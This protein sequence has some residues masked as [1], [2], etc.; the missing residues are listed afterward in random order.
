MNIGKF[1]LALLG[2]LMLGFGGAA[3]AQD[4][5]LSR[6]DALQVQL[7]PADY[8]PVCGERNGK[9]N[10]FQ[11]FCVAKSYGYRVL[12]GGKCR[13]APVPQ[14]PQACPRIYDPVCAE[15]RGVRQT[16]SNDC[17]AETRGYRV[18]YEGQC[19]VAPEPPQVCPRNYAPVCA[20]RNGKRDT[21]SND[22]VAETG[23]YRVVYEGQCRVAPEPPQVCP[24]NYAPVCAERNGK[25]DTFS[26]D[27][28]AE[29]RG[30]RVISEG[31]CQIAPRPPKPPR[32]E[33]CSDEYRPV[34]GERNGVR[35]TF[36]NVCEG[37]A[38]GYRLLYDSACSTEV[39]PRQPNVK[40]PRKWTDR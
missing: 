36:S 23:G 32:P 27:C 19:R 4:G 12:Y 39:D 35:Q 18:V 3:R 24:R 20:E 31:E 2:V 33:V 38:S 30:Y 5:D 9:R 14:E 34:C 15:R 13:I 21:F 10:S 40:K 8:D 25:R 22:C 6:S 16:F 1:I 29:T 37:K 28:I 17:I 7:C 11:N 26:N